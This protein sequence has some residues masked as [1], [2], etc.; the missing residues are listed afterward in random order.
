MWI[1]C[2]RF[3]LWG[4]GLL[5]W[6]IF[7]MATNAFSMSRSGGASNWE[8]GGSR[9]PP[10]ALQPSSVGWHPSPHLPTSPWMTSRYKWEA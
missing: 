5:Q 3:F 2:G 6:N 7:L 4:M 9:E 10:P 1:I 8:R